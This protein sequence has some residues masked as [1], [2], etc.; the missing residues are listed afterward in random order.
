MDR[1]RIWIQN[2]SFRIHSINSGFEF[3]ACT[4]LYC[5]DTSGLLQVHIQK[6]I[7]QPY[8]FRHSR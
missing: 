3:C 8:D 1:I 6:R 2:K 5:T 7:S 4:V